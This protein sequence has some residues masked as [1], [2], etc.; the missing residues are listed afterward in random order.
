MTQVP[1]GVQMTV[2]GSI[3]IEGGAEPA[4]VLRSLSRFYA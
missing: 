1:G 4:A 2:D 3:E